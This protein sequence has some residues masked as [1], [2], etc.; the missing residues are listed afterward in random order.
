MHEEMGAVH[1]TGGSQGLRCWLVDLS[2]L[3]KLPHADETPNKYMGCFFADMFF[4]PTY[5]ARTYGFSQCLKIW[6]VWGMRGMFHCAPSE[7]NTFVDYMKKKCVHPE[8]SSFFCWVSESWEAQSIYWRMIFW[9]PFICERLARKKSEREALETWSGSRVECSLQVASDMDPVSP[10]KKPLTNLV[11][12]RVVV[13]LMNK[14]TKERNIEKHIQIFSSKGVCSL[15]SN[16]LLENPNPHKTCNHFQIPKSKWIQIPSI[17]RRTNLW[18]LR[19]RS[20]QNIQK[21]SMS[22]SWEYS[23]YSQIIK[24]SQNISIF[25]TPNP[26]IQ[27][28]DSKIIDL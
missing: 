15:F 19:K 2:R 6:C 10:Q 8:Y 1:L 12:Q 23:Q 3:L 14:E 17:L 25:S 7:G 11:F 4:Y 22:W 5:T 28:L 9:Q 16:R 18:K 24:Y 21:Y 20:S 13:E 27:K 26:W